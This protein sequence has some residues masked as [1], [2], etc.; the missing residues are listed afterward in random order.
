MEKFGRF[1]KE[2]ACGGEW[3]RGE[4]GGRRGDGEG[5]DGWKSE[6]GREKG[7]RRASA[8]WDGGEEGERSGRERMGW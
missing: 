6:M 3:K 8:E 7:R 2:G 5:K 4:E 1:E